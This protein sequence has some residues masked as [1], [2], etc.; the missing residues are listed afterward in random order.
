MFYF[1][2]VYGYSPSCLSANLQRGTTFVISVCFPGGETLLKGST[3]KR[4]NL[5][6]QSKFFSLKV[7]PNSVGRHKTTIKE[8]L[9]S[10]L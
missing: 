1:H 4:K 3:L 2:K 8:L 6:L 7:D 10:N 9:P 5:L